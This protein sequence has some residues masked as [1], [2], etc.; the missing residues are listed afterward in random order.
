MKRTTIVGQHPEYIV[1]DTLTPKGEAAITPYT[2]A[3]VITFYE[4][5]GGTGGPTIHDALSG[6]DAAGFVSGMF[7]EVLGSTNN[8]GVYL[9]AG[10]YYS[11]VLILA[12]GYELSDETAGAGAVTISTPTLISPLG[13]LNNITDL[14]QTITNPPTQA[15]VQAL[16]DKVD[17]ILAKLRISG[18]II[19]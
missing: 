9:I 18:I 19:P 4:N 6:F 7:I 10:Y 16:S 5:F 2:S 3:G 14:N 11:Q 15:E 8:D 17:E 12:S 13:G 1:D